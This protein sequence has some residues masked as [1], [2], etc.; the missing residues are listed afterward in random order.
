MPFLVSPRT[1]LHQTAESDADDE[2]Q[3]DEVQ[4]V[5]ECPAA[6]DEEVPGGAV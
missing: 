2:Q 5:S 1:S 3:T 6:G 4:E